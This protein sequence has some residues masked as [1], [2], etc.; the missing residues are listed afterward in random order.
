MLGAGDWGLGGWGQGGCVNRSHPYANLVSGAPIPF[1]IVSE[2]QMQPNE[3]EMGKVEVEIEFRNFLF[4][5]KHTPPQWHIN[6][7]CVWKPPS[8]R[9]QDPRALQPSAPSPQAL[10]IGGLYVL[11]PNE[12]QHLIHYTTICRIMASFADPSFG[13]FE[14]FFPLLAAL[15]EKAT[16]HSRRRPI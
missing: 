4:G 1:R 9:S 2:S 3:R 5:P 7:N 6:F 12:L 15:R 14:A 10:L 16:P 13:G 8:A 11:W